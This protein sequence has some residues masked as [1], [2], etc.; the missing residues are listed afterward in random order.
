MGKKILKVLGV[1]LLVIIG[2][3]VAAP[4]VLEAKIGELIK[5]NV[6]N[7]VNATLDFSEAN[8]SLVRSFPNAEVG[9]KNLTL[10]NKDPF[11]GDTLFA[12]KA[13]ALKMGIS[14][15]FKSEAD[16]IGIKSLIIDGAVLNITV[17]EAENANYDI[18]KESEVENA[19]ENGNSS[20]FQLN[21][22]VYELTNSHISYLDKATGMHLLLS[23][24]QHSGTGDLSL[25]TSELQTL[26]D[27]LVSFEMDS[28]NYL[29]KNKIQL[30]ALIGIDLKE[31]KYSFLK[32]KAF[33]NQLPLVFN[34]FVQ[35]NEDYQEVDISFKTPSSDFKNF[36]AVIPEVY[37]K[38]IENVETTGNF[39]VEGR[40]NGIVDEK[41]IPKFNISVLSEN[42]SFK[43]PDL[44]KTVRNVYIDTKINNT[45]G[46]V[47]DTYVDIDRLSFKIDEDQF[48]MMAKI[49]EL[50]GNTR[51]NAHV[52]G[53]MHLAN[54]S[55]AYPVPADLNLK[56]LLNADI[57][58]AFDM[59]SIENQQY[60]NTQTTG[61]MSLEDFEYS[62][63][64]VAHPIALQKTSISFNPTTVTLNQLNGTTGD[65]DFNATGTINNLLGFVFNDEQVKGSF[66]LN[67]N[68]FALNDFMVPDEET[69]EEKEEADAEPTTTGTA[70]E[71]IKIPSFL[72][73]TINASANTVLYDDI[74]L[75][76]VKGNL[77][78]KD[79]K[80][81]LSNM[82]SSLFDG[83][84]SF[85]GEVST[86][87]ETPTFAMNL[88]L[89][90]LE[91]GETFQSLELFKVLAPITQIVQGKLDSDIQLAGNL[92]DDFS[93]DLLSL[94]GNIL[95]NIFTR[96]IDTR[97]TPVLSALDTKLDF[98]DLKEL[99]LDALKTKLSFENGIVSVQP[100]TIKYKD[101]AINVDGGHTFDQKLNY[102]ATMEVPA[103]Y[104]G[105]EVNSLIAKID[106]SSLE[107]MTIPVKAT[108]GGVYNSPAVT[109]DF[110]SGVKS[111]T[112]QL[113]EVQKQKLV[114]QGKDKAKDL[115]GN[116]LNG[117]KKENDSAA[118]ANETSSGVKEVL[119]GLLGSEKKTDS[120][121][122]D[123]EASKKGEDVVKEKAKNILGGL[124]G[125]KKKKDTSKDK[126]DSVN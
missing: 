22:E 13:V 43:Y 117:T 12:A 98:I 81:I 93:P 18:G 92:T 23:D 8:L 53:V 88:G 113:V 116:L 10:I 29:N 77:R 50:M 82:T 64:E 72:D 65:T 112:N 49:R 90:K 118:N 124:L 61:S 105:S 96:E 59:A 28:T 55:K 3:L 15:L 26:T 20:G 99:N 47:E 2:I 66:D 120:V 73:A 35:L 16:P 25:E 109:T 110:A 37:S 4:F 79:E 85:N 57:T 1:L 103:K 78:I 80:A 31:N 45:T 11:E 89:E 7:N 39:E 56:G 95:A 91:V 32:N 44:P 63:E 71:K 54:I 69:G 119:G 115:I 70:E 100:F 62:S 101:V 126:K 42:A 104:L 125:G 94:S 111:L 76:N 41:H 58:T 19:P 97:K 21:L 52:D 34:G 123:A 114:N 74:T 86:K 6:N 5:N 87:E 38:N 40:F 46:I 67:S 106:D 36:L 84:V 102:T 24:I 122:T 9:L 17:D 33:I 48:N 107:N 51:V 75:K 30:D 27:A 68:T 121:K 108:I 14:E 83:K 60:E